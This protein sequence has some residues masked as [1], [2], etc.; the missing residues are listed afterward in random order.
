MVGEQLYRGPSGVQ[1]AEDEEP[2]Q[3]PGT[4]PGLG[5]PA[6]DQREDQEELDLLT[7]EG[8]RSQRV[9]TADQDAGYGAQ[10]ADGQVRPDQP[11]EGAIGREIHA[12][13][14]EPP[15]NCQHD[16]DDVLGSQIET[17]SRH[18][19]WKRHPRRETDGGEQ[20]GQAQQPPGQ[21]GP[22]G[23]DA[24]AAG[25]DDHGAQSRLPTA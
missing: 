17:L 7:P 22:D 1:V 2:G 19:D 18:G 11:P 8:R 20:D 12:W 25:G 16:E 23:C 15:G 9:E 6:G 14:S 5:R 3:E 24:K 4:I 21:L 10:K 13:S